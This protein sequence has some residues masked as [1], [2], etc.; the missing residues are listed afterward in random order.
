MTEHPSPDAADRNRP[1]SIRFDVGPG[2][3]LAAAWVTLGRPLAAPEQIAEVVEEAISIRNRR[4]N[5]LGA[6]RL[7]LP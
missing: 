7:K 4:F 1:I 5:H 6:G 3:E 2:A